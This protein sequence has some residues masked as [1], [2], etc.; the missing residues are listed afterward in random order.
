MM[1]RIFV[2]ATIEMHS[3]LDMKQLSAAGGADFP[4]AS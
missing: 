2:V 1:L 4:E 3:W